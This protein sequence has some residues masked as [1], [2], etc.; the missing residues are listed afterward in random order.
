MRRI[1]SIVVAVGF[2]CALSGCFGPSVSVPSY[3]ASAVASA[4]MSEYD[5]NKDG[6][7]DESE[8][9]RSPALKNALVD[10]DKNKDQAIGRDELEERLSEFL[11]SKVGLVG[12]NCRVVKGGAPVADVEVKFIPEKFFG[13]AISGGTGK[14]DKN[15]SVE[16]RTE[17]K[18]LPGLAPGFYRVELSKKDGGGAETMP[19]I[20]NEKSILGYQ[21][22]TRM[23]SAIRIEIQ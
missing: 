21:I 14:S 19:A 11:S 22:H 6:K 4:A 5:T 20:Y 2:V 13:T 17:G 8:L 15:G 10:L 23:K 12:V 9:L 1:G 18:S 7:L 16:I 3:S